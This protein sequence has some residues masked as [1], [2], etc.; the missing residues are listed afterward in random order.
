MATRKTV[1]KEPIKDK[2]VVY[3]G[4]TIG[5]GALMRYSV[6]KSGEFPPHVVELRQ[7][8]EALRG[9]FVPVSQLAVARQRLTVKGD[10][11]NIYV[12]QL[13]TEL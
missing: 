2:A 11:L 6:F 4:P 12:Q 9:L 10:L 13:K 3:V 1:K 8:S 5:S 7:K